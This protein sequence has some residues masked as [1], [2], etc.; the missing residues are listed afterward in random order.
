MLQRGEQKDVS[1]NITTQDLKFYNTKLQY[2]WEP[3]QFIVQIGTNSS[4]VHAASVQWN[5]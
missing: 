2:D 5:K 4:D 3:G 1:F